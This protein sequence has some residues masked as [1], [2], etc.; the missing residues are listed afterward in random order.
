[1][2]INLAHAMTSLGVPVEFVLSSATGEFIDTLDSSIPL[3]DLSAGPV[4]R[5]VFPLA[6]Y[7]RTRRPYALITRMSH[8][9]VIA[10]TAHKLSRSRSRLVLT[11]ATQIS[12]LLSERALWRRWRHRFVLLPLVRLTYPWADAV[13]AVSQG[14]AADFQNMVRTLRSYPIVL[15]NPVVDERLLQ[16]AAKQPSHPWWSSAAQANREP[17]IVSIGRLCEAKDYATLLRAFAIARTKKPMRLV[18]FGEGPQRSMLEKLRSSL[19]LDDCID[20]PGY[21]ENPY[22]MLSRSSLFVLSSKREGSPNALTESLACG[23]PVAATNCPSGPAEILEHGRWGPL[24]PP[25]NAAL[26]AK[27]ICDAL[28]APRRSNELQH[29]ATNFSARQAAL[30]YLQLI[31]YPVMQLPYYHPAAAA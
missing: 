28:D 30:S 25:G 16:L 26:L 19:G 10:A 22:A 8:A 24:I 12:G 4:Q 1:M 6:R 7:L 23:C 3:V 27:A 17:I 20:L 14:V 29:R 13:V 11:E 15:A 5:A 9:N 2:M 31:Q 21:C 18:I